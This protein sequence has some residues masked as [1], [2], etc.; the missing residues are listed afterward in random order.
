M[1]PAR[2]GPQ[3]NDSLADSNAQRRNNRARIAPRVAQLDDE[4]IG[5]LGSCGRR[6]ATGRQAT[7]VE[8]VSGVRERS[9]CEK[10]ESSKTDHRT[11]DWERNASI[12]WSAFSAAENSTPYDCK[13]W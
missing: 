5:S 4:A 3:V 2:H 9:K 6:D 8:V 10:G 11:T 1:R 7:V 12:V 13:R